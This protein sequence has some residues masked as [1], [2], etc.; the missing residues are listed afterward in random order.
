MLIACDI[1]GV[2]RDL[3][4]GNLINDA[5]T[6]ITKIME[7]HRLIFISKCGQKYRHEITGWLIEHGLHHIPIFFCDDCK[8]KV[9]I[10][11]G[12]KVDIMI[13][14]KLKVLNEFSKKVKLLWFCND[15]KKISGAKKYQPNIFEKVILMESWEN[16]LEFLDE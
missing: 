11:L 14:D 2:V 10:A 9:E 13:D 3:S 16:I 1:G 15:N 12:N 4:T 7:K 5:V 8:D 6:S